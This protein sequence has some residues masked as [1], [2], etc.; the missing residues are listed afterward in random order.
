MK[1]GMPTQNHTPTTK[2][3]SK[4][5]PEVKFQYGGRLFSETGNSNISAMD[6]VALSKCS[7][8]IDFDIPNC[9]TSP[10]RKPDVDLRRCGRHTKNGYD[11][12]TWPS[13]RIRRWWWQ[14]R[15]SGTGSR[16]SIW[17]PFVFRPVVISKP[18]IEL[19]GWDI[20]NMQIVLDVLK[21][22]TSPKRKQIDLTWQLRYLSSNSDKN[23]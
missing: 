12:I 13:R 20:A 21:C 14:K 9:G 8:Q 22:D 23:L 11:V 15:Q 3:T 1:F 5:K 4:R 2:E 16:I 17:R 19:F 10:K 7:M 18:Q 6:G